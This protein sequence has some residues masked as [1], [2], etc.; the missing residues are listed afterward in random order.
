MDSIKFN[1]IN[2]LKELGTLAEKIE[3]AAEEWKLNSNTSYKINLCLDELVTNTISYGFNDNKEHEIII[4]LNL[5]NDNEI[6]I[7]IIDDGI[8]FNPLKAEAP[9]L[10]S[11]LE[12]KKLGG[13][14]IY[15]VKKFMDKVDYFREGNKNILKLIKK[16]I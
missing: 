6:Q 9:D 5:N 1:I 3:F 11:E 16:L 7:I 14:G 15:F 10:D 2:D 13:L 8:E 4:E 12:D